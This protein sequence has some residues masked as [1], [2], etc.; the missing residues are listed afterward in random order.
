MY[1]R[2]TT[3]QV[4]PGKMD[5]SIQIFRDSV[6]PAARQQPGFKG[7]WELVDRSN[8]KAIAITLWETEADLKAGETSGYFQEQV[9]KGA[10]VLVGS[11]VREI[12]EVAIE[13]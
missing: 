6:L 9:A 2:I 5:D 13:A 3:I 10:S 8:N 11:P 12:Y 1:A 7:L 4:Q